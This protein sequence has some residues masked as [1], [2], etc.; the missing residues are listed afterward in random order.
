MHKNFFKLFFRNILQH[1]TL[2]AINILGLVVGML[3]TILILEYVFYENSYDN[4]HDN[5]NRIYRV[6]YNRYQNEELLWKTANS[7]YPTGSYLKTNYSE[8]EDYF[9]FQRSNNINISLT[10]GY[11]KEV[12][13]NE[14]KT[15]FVT[16]GIFNLLKVE[17]LK[18]TSSC[19]DEPN[20]VAIS[21]KVAKRYF[22]NNDPIGKTIEVNHDKNYTIS[23]VYKD[24]PSNTHLKTDFLFSFVTLLNENPGWKSNWGFDYFTAYL[25]LKPGVDYKKFEAKAFPEMIAANY[26]ERLK[27][28]GIT[29][30][31]YLQPI[32]DIHLKSN[33]EYETDEPG[34]QKAVNILFAFAIFFL[35]VAWINYINLTSARAVERAKE[36]GIKKIS[37]ITKRS[38]IGQFFL[39]TFILNGL[40][41]FIT[42]GLLLIIQPYFLE[43]TKMTGH[44]NLLPQGFWMHA[45]IVFILGTFLS[46]IY[47]SLVLSGFKPVTILKGQYAKSEQGIRFRKVLVTFQFAISLVL[48]SGTIITY[49]QVDFLLQKDMGINP[50]HKLV[51]KAPKPKDSQNELFNK[52]DKLSNDFMQMPEVNDFTFI[53]DI[54]GQEIQ[55]WY[56]IRKPSA[57]NGSTQGQ[58]R[59]DVDNN[60]IDFFEIKLLAGRGFYKDELENSDKI[61]VNLKGM[62]RAGF[63]SPEEAV[64]ATVL[65]QRNRELQII[66][67]VEDFQYYSV[68]VEAIPTVIMNQNGAK[69]YMALELKPSTWNNLNLV[70][71]KLE[72]VFGETFAGEPFDY[73]ILE[74]KTAKVLQSDKT[75]SRI[76]GMFSLLAIIIASIGILGLIIITINQTTK[77]LAIRK[78]HGAK[79]GNLFMILSKNLIPQFVIAIIIALPLTYYIF[80]NLVLSNYL[81]RISLS[82]S[83]FILPVA[84]ILAMF[85]ALVFFQTKKVIRSSI[86]KV[87]VME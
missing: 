19:L 5:A 36:I 70:L 25:K 38:L 45:T 9:I 50:K 65:G 84:F 71:K 27:Q 11:N 81:Y 35:L 82:W 31:Y 3:S 57:E 42:L 63:S 43:L 75:F 77:E 33:I 16:D 76:F 54:P 26:G 78:A 41:L 64:N 2:S 58:F 74:D 1:K 51:I 30:N 24:F 48:L 83:Y 37:G 59:L 46:A 61:L 60:F 32:E 40:C 20:K 21:D 49:K 17:L 79:A 67:V 47:P 34:N 72:A 4:Y 6:A 12:S 85:A 55:Q 44:Q 73:L 14:E 15:Y 23:A 52:I 68:K 80:N 10:D 56:G 62:E 7:F 18:G 29:D 28:R 69:A 8:V 87:L 66:G 39:E 13:F 86:S 22:G 53:S